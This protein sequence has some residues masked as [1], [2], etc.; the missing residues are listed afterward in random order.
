MVNR[1]KVIIDGRVVATRESKNRTYT[2]CVLVYGVTDNE[3][4][5][6]ALYRQYLSD[7]LATGDQADIGLV[8]QWVANTEIRIRKYTDTW[9]PVGWAGTPA[10]AAKYAAQVKYC[11]SDRVRVVPAVA[12]PAGV[13][14]P[15]IGDPAP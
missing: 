6:L 1:Y 11:P 7:A 15:Q 2:H 10:L 9:H 4:G 3:L 14:M 13:S 12:V 5:Q 8:A